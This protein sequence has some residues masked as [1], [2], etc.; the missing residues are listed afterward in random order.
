[1]KR[2]AIMALLMLVPA[3]VVVAADD[4]PSV[5]GSYKITGLS[6]GGMKAPEEVTKSFEGVTIKGDKLKLKIAG[7]PEMVAT[8]KVD[9]KAKP[10]ASID[11]TA[12]DGPEK[13]KTMLG[14]WKLEEYLQGSE[15][16]WFDILGRGVHR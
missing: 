7:S 11:M 3:F 6:K 16:T 13:G 5:D 2:F 9:S 4:P 8:I 10:F 15:A 14:I 12:D 1:M